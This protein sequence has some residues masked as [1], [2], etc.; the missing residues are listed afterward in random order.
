MDRQ[1]FAFIDW[2]KSLG[3]LL[4]VYGHVASSSIEQFTP[5]IYPK[6]LGV[7]FFVFIIGWGLARES[8]DR[9]KVVY[10][11]LFPVFFVG[12]GMAV[13]MS[14]IVFF[15]NGQLN[16][17][18]YLPFLLGVNVLVDN[19]P[20]NPTTWYIGTYI[21]ILILWALLMYRLRVR[22][23]MV[24]AAAVTEICYRA[25]MLDTGA[26]YRTYMML[27]NWITVF[28]FGMF[29]HDR[30][31]ETRRVSLLIYALS[32]VCLVVAWDLAARGV[33]FD[34]AF[35][36]R[37]STSITLTGWSGLVMRAASVTFLYVI[38]TWLVFEITRRLKEYAMV[39][40]FARQTLFIFVAHMPILF[41]LQRFLPQFIF[42]YWYRVM[43]S[44]L[45][46]YVGLAF[47]SEWI[48]RKFQLGIV[49]DTLW[50]I[51]QSERPLTH[52]IKA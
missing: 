47:V 7:A 10:D 22:M 4:I 26:L 6:Q 12:I 18:N 34:A 20:A 21:H 41:A 15:T 16:P 45:I 52:V 11:R 46:L 31:Q 32:L 1:H 8:R 40:F 42:N 35:P 27:P 29:M 13:V 51:V 5:P 50:R 43:I 28:L 49:R 48:I 3:M 17:S 14:V 2:M 36:F 38:Y 37:N 44:M 24:A 33:T 39:R 19:F 25:T 23:W 9:L 30:T